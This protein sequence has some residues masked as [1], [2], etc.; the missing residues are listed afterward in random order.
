MIWV[1]GFGLAATVLLNAPAVAQSATTPLV[2]EV[3]VAPACAASAN[4]TGH[5]IC[6]VSDGNHNLTAV[7]M[8]TMAGQFPSPPLDPAKPMP[9]GVAGTLSQ[10]G[11]ASTADDSG[12]IV[13]AYES[14]SGNTEVFGIRFNIFSGTIFPVQVVLPN[15][16]GV[17]SCTNGNQRFTVTGPANAETPAGATICA[18]RNHN[19]VLISFAFNPATGYEQTLRIGG[20]F[21]FTPSC[22]NSNDGKN[23]VICAMV[24]EDVNGTAPF[25]LAGAAFDPRTGFSTGIVSLFGGSQAFEGTGTSSLPGSPGCATAD[26]SGQVICAVRG[27]A[28]SLLGFAFDPRTGFVSNLQTLSN[29]VIFGTPSCAGLADGSKQVVCAVNA[30]SNSNAVLENIM[31]VKFDPRTGA[32]SGLVNTGF[33]SSKTDNAVITNPAGDFFIDLSCTFENINPAQV[34]C[35]GAVTSQNE[36]FGILLDP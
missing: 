6:V 19:G 2:T 4:G 30:F 8:Q 17:P 25:A 29:T 11:C 16:G 1:A 31:A 36:F 12:D 22:T 26:N 34:S 18:Y 27:S 32:N 15:G 23:Q 14:L 20:D 5:M 35:G 7:S 33:S 3:A 9:L 13:C 21:L 28:N 10:N 24:V